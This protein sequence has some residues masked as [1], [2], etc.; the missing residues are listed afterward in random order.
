VRTW[1]ALEVGR[2]TEATPDGPELFQAAL[3]DYQV[4]AIA[5]STPDTWRVFFDSTRERDRAAAALP[6]QFQG[7]SINPVDVPDEDWVA[8]SQAELRAVRVGNIIIAPPWDVPQPGTLVLDPEF[9]HPPSGEPIIVVIRPSTGF[10]TAHHATTRLC[11]G[12]L[13][14]LDVR[15]RGVVDVGTGSGVLA[16]AASRLGAASVVGVDDDPDALQASADNLTLN[17]DA[18]VTLHEGDVRS[19]GLNGFDLVM[20]NLTGALLEAAALPL[21]SLGKAGG[22]LVLSGLLEEEEATV[23]SAYA[24]CVVH[25][26]SQEGEWLCVSLQQP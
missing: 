22:Y 10:G 15:G 3:V 24:G 21:Q 16:I 9:S 23:L 20:A 7:L 6:D 11:L 26:R 1:P 8:R 19:L 4:A 18:K 17:R 13:Q 5:E 25:N 14:R 12:A 2:L